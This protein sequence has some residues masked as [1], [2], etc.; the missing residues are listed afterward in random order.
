LDENGFPDASFGNSGF[1][2]ASTMTSLADFP[3]IGTV[4]QQ[5]NGQY[6]AMAYNPFDGLLL[7]RFNADGSLDNSFAST[8]FELHRS[9]LFKS[10]MDSQDRLVV[11]CFYFPDDNI[12]QNMA[13]LGIMR[14]TA[15]GMLDQSFGSGGM[16]LIG[17][18][19]FDERCYDVAVDGQDRVYVAGYR[20][21]T[22]NPMHSNARVY[23]LDVNG[24]LRGDFAVNGIYELNVAGVNNGFSGVCLAN[25]GDVLACGQQFNAQTWI[26]QGTIVRISSS[27]TPVTSFGAEGIH[28]SD[29]ADAEYKSV[30]ELSGDGTIAVAVK[31]NN[32]DFG[33]DARVS[34]VSATGYPVNSFGTTG[35][36]TTFDIGTGDESP[37]DIHE[38]QAGR[39]L[40]TGHGNSYIDLPQLGIVSGNKG[41]VACYAHAPLA[42]TSEPLEESPMV[43]PNPATEFVRLNTAVDADFIIT[44]TAGRCMLKGRSNNRVV[45]IRELPSG[46]YLL[47][48]GG[49][50]YRIVKE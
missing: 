39:I 20:T 41:F 17:D 26:Q 43:F 36:S 15:D 4:A 40:V 42:G 28:L 31:V 9:G 48:A 5:S 38:D 3:Y 16:V 44:D 14:F 50:S 30:V 45:D 37:S 21:E 2:D 29:D 18:L 32:G 24:Q 19:E 34:L 27:G 6:V 35:H 47:N 12:Y 33:R 49:E 10:V 8:P 1:V 25:N 46:M 7:V 22:T 23:A 13:N 11:S